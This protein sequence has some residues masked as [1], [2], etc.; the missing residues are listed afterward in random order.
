MSLSHSVIITMWFEKSQDSG[1]AVSL[2]NN[3]V[4]CGKITKTVM[5]LSHSVIITMWF[6]KSQ[7]SGIAVSPSNNH[8][9]GGKI[10]RQ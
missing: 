7:D 8:V 1:V 5:S 4:V 9:V 2:S 6:E 3:H 10:T